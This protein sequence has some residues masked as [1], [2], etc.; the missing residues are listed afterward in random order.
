MLGAALLFTPA[1]L[2]T[3]AGHFAPCVCALARFAIGDLFGKIH[4]ITLALAVFVS[5]CY[6]LPLNI[7]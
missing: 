5:P 4:V 3:S 1:P 7:C 2:S 6:F